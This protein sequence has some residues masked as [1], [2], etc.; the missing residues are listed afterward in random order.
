LG[1]K[2]DYYRNH[3]FLKDYFL[4]RG[5]DFWGFEMP[6]KK[7]G[8][9][10]EED[11]RLLKR[12]YDKIED[13]SSEGERG[14]DSMADVVRRLE[15]RHEARITELESMPGR[16]QKSIWWPFT[17]HGLVSTKDTHPCTLGNKLY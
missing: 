3:E 15:E 12:W 14:G 4:E 6:H 9:S 8:L 16:T 1:L 10:M 13:G 7:E 11:V 2:D 17:Q 5:I